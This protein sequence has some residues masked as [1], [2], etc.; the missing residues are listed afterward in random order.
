M[1]RRDSSLA[2]RKMSSDDWKCGDN[3]RSWKTDYPT[4][5]LSLDYIQAVSST[6]TKS[7]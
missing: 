2:H 7:R 1:R 3:V 4:I 5:L 6:D